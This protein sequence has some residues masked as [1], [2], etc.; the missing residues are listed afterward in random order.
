[1][2]GKLIIFDGIDGSGKTTVIAAAVNFL[3]QRKKVFD[4]VAWSK[5]NHALPEAAILKRY[6]VI[7]SAEPTHTWIGAAI[8]NE[9]IRA[10]GNYT[11]KDAAA[12]FALDRKILYT[13][14]VVPA[15]LMGKLVLQDRSVSSSIAYQ[16][17]QKN[18]APLGFVL[19]LAGNKLALKYPPDAIIIASCPPEVALKRLHG[20]KNKKDNV[21]F[22]QLAFMKKLSARFHAVWY[23][24][25]WEKRGTKI[26]YINTND[27]RSA[28]EK[29]VKNYLHQFLTIHP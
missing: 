16:P 4:L 27:P 26:V 6:D 8:R 17:I 1:M 5:K 3:K 12:A 29:S 19:S 13:R 10:G 24:K 18:P 2:R 9:I 20:R 23:K 28:V 11:G 14:C 7:L 25:F 15:L 21:I 22:E